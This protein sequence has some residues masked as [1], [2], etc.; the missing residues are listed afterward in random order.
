MGNV[1]IGKGKDEDGLCVMVPKPKMIASDLQHKSSSK[2]VSSPF[3]IHQSPPQSSKSP[4]SLELPLPPKNKLP[5][6]QKTQT[7]N[8]PILAFPKVTQN[9]NITCGDEGSYGC[10]IDNSDKK[11]QTIIEKLDIDKIV[12]HGL[13]STRTLY[14]DNANLQ[15]TINKLANSSFKLFKD[16]NRDDVNDAFQVE[17]KAAKK[18]FKLLGT[19]STFI[20]DLGVEIKLNTP[21]QIT[22]QEGVFSHYELYII[23]QTFCAE[24]DLLSNLLIGNDIDIEKMYKDISKALKIL[25]NNGY[26]HRDIKLE[27]IVKCGDEYKLIDFGFTIEHQNGDPNN[28][29][30][31]VGYIHPSLGTNDKV[32]ITDNAISWFERNYRAHPFINTRPHPD[33]LWYKSDEYALACVI[34]VLCIEQEGHDVSENPFDSNFPYY[35]ILNELCNPSKCF[36]KTNITKGGNTIFKLYSKYCAQLK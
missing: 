27:N 8:Y 19:K 30:G 23:P 3:E 14:K 18:A 32:Y 4:P 1:C 13:H 15:S 22:S 20:E 31:T 6:I 29:S 5:P 35:Q 34:Y 11:Y 21:I 16:S 10:I 26:V 9:P 36:L 17:I 24:K 28:M 33:I 7:F 2:I 25:H 12:V